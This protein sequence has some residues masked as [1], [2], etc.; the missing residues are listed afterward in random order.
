[1]KLRWCVLGLVAMAC[2]AAAVWAPG[3]LAAAKDGFAPLFNGKD[4]KGWSGDSRLWKV[5]DGCIVGSTD[6][7]KIEKNTFLFSEKEYGDF[8]LRVK[9]KLRNHNSGVQFRSEQRPDFVAAGYQADV[10]EKTY[11]GML[12]EEQ[13]RGFMDYWKAM[14]P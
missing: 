9:V 11:F 10:A 3:A 13:K 4:L 14:S 12:Y 6:G 1:M 7:V 2:V 8:V 5:A